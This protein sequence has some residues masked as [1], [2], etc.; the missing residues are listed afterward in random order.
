MNIINSIR[1][2]SIGLGIF[3][4]LTAGLI[5]LT[6]QL[7]EHTIEDNIVQSQLSAFNEILPAERYDNNLA[8]QS[9][10]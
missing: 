9:A 8:K 7:T 4:V 2:N 1:Q 10:A 5:A 6:H 3:A